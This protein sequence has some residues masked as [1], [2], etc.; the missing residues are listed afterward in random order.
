P[1]FGEPQQVVA[2]TKTARRSVTSAGDLSRVYFAPLAGTAEEAR[3]IKSLFPAARVLT[4]TRARKTELAQV[5]APII[6]HIAT[7]GFFL[8]QATRDAVPANAAAHITRGTSA[9]LAVQNPLLR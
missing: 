3:T 8:Q 9:T 2:A 4:G 6:L 5:N 1:L 7:H